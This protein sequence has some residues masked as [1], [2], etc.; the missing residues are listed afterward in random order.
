MLGGEKQISSKSPRINAVSPTLTRNMDK[1]EE[2]EVI[3]GRRSPGGWRREG[4][5]PQMGGQRDS[6]VIVMKSDF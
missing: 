1:G 6:T 5:E 4:A 2:E 3:S